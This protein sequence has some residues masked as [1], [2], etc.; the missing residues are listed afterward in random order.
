MTGQNITEKEIKRKM[1]AIESQ[2][3]Q[4]EV[5]TI[6]HISKPSQPTGQQNGQQNNKN[7]LNKNKSR[8]IN[9]QEPISQHYRHQ[10]IFDIDSKL[11][12]D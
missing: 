4:K 11:L 8:D 6:D 3:K 7:S 1:L 9:Q 10:G 12:N 5:I 2:L